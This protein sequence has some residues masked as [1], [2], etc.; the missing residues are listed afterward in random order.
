MQQRTEAPFPGQARPLRELL[1]IAGASLM[2]SAFV[3][4]WA[5]VAD[6]LGPGSGSTTV[7][8][9][10]QLF[11]T[12]RSFFLLSYALFTLA[13]SLSIVGA[14]GIYFV[15]RVQNMSYAILGVGTLIVGF[16]ATLLSSTTPA[17]LMLSSGYAAS[18][19]LDQQIFVSAALAVFSMDNPIIASIFIGVGVIFVSLALIRSPAWRLLAY[20]GLIVGALNIVRALPSL[21]GEAFVTGAIFV[22]VSSIWIFGV[23]RRVYTEG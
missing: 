12:Y 19:P 21:A 23:G 22:A 16:V 18:P 8:A 7:Q 6:Y 17:L 2:V 3:Y 13:N 1:R 14:F 5:F 11:A 9:A 20:L 15:A 10:L 4:V